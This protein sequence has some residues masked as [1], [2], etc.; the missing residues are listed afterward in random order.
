MGPV[1][2]PIAGD[3]VGW[4]KGVLAGLR[5]VRDRDAHGRPVTAPA[6]RRP[7]ERWGLTASSGGGAQG[8]VVTGHDGGNATHG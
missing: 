2:S 8:A 3:G 5:A 4:T 1:T 6:A 7:L